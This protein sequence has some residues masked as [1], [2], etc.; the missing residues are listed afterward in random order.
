MS[1]PEILI[2]LI[3]ELQDCQYDNID[4]SD[5][6]KTVIFNYPGYKTI[7]TFSDRLRTCGNFN[8]GKYSRL[9]QRETISVH[10]MTFIFENSSYF[11]V[12]HDN[13]VR[14]TKELIFRI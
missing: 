10:S 9:N 2:E 13:S 12:K 14:I 5:D 6:V 4:T 3:R 7:Y 8:R 1:N 11:S